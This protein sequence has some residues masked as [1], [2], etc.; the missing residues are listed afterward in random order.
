[1]PGCRLTYAGD[2]PMLK[3]LQALSRDRF[4]EGAVRFLGRVPD[5]WPLYHGA[6]VVLLCSRTEGVP[7]VV[8]EATL[9]GV[10]TVAWD[11]GDIG[12]VLFDGA[13]GRLTPY[14]DVAALALA[15]RE[16]IRSHEEWSRLRESTVATAA[17]MSFDSIAD[18]YI[19]ALRLDERLKGRAP[20]SASP[21]NEGTR[22]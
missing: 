14:G 7:G 22:P 16:A 6:G 4:P 12:Q 15:L 17:S 3:P 1:M 18:A 11:V 5:I 8:V 20:L 21:P 9:A 13:N 19:H 2:G 10:P